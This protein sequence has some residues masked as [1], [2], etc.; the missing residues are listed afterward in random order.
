MR[1]QE[2]QI[3]EKDCGDYWSVAGGIVDVEG[4]RKDGKGPVIYKKG[5]KKFTVPSKDSGGPRIVKHPDNEKPTGQWN[6]IELMTVGPTSV[7]IVNGKI[8]LRL[9]NSRYIL[10]CKETPLTKGKI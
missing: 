10:D 8:V 6:T 1:S 9:T 4:E 2:L 7:H 3:Q 5:G